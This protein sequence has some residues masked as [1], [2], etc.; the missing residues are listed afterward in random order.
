MHDDNLFVTLT[1]ELLI[2]F[3]GIKLFSQTFSWMF[4][5]YHV[6]YTLYVVPYVAYVVTKYGVKDFTQFVIPCLLRPDE[7]SGR[8]VNSA[9]TYAKAVDVSTNQYKFQFSS[10]YLT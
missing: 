7:L 10:L 1:F 9:L 5:I 4:A 6:I 8:I 3:G 2:F